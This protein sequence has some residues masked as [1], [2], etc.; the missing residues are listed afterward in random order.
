MSKKI[1]EQSKEEIEKNFL[2]EDADV[3]LEQKVVIANEIPLMEKII[4]QNFRDPGLTL[5]FHYASKTHPLKRYA[6][7]HGQQYLLPVEIVKH[8]E[9]QSSMDPYSCHSRTYSQRIRADG[10]HETFVSGYNPYFRCQP[11]RA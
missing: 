9:G 6:L 5:E 4:F 10:I 11:V 8:L 7:I 3:L 2:Q 1:N